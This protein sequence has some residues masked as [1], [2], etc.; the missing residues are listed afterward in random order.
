MGNKRLALEEYEILERTSPN[1]A[2]ILYGKI[3]K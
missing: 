2:N 3:F 1:L